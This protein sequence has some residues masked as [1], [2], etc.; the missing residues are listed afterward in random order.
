MA[1]LKYRDPETGEVKTVGAPAPDYYTKEEQDAKLEEKAEAIH[2]EQ[3]AAGGSDAITPEMIG[4]APGGFGLGE[5]IGNLITDGNDAVRGGNYYWGSVGT[6][7][8]FTYGHMRVDV[9][10]DGGS[11]VQTAYPETVDMAGCVAQRKRV[12]KDWQP[13]EWVNPP[14][15]LGQEYRTTERYEG[16]PVYVK[17]VDCGNLPNNSTAVINFHENNNRA[18]FSVHGIAGGDNTIP[19]TE[20]WGNKANKIGVQ[21]V[22]NNIYITTTWDATAYKAVVIVK[23][24]NLLD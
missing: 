19:T 12:D 9:R 17:A 20:W 11:L 16:K 1:V 21:G 22:D 7:L 2:A 14:M 8:P 10:T 18:A 4:A 13:W 5:T 23:Y 24:R 3:H 6:N 15:V